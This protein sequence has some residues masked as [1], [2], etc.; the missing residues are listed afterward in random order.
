MKVE[1][2]QVA[3]IK[4]DAEQAAKMERRQKRRCEEEAARVKAEEA[5]VKAE[6]VRLK[7]PLTGKCGLLFAGAS[8]SNHSDC[9]GRSWKA[10]TRVAAWIEL[11]AL[12]FSSLPVQRTANASRNEPQSSIASTAAPIAPRSSLGETGS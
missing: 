11:L 3:K 5:R 1:H 8:A 6:G 7:A 2:E 12:S 9:R 10:R 4:A